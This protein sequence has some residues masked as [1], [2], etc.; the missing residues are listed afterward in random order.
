MCK[1][2]SEPGGP[3]RC[4]G[5]VRAKL[6]ASVA[7]VE[8]LETRHETL[9]RT[10]CELAVVTGAQ[11]HRA[12]SRSRQAAGR[13]DELREEIYEY[14][15]DGAALSEYRTVYRELV[16]ANREANALDAPA[17][18]AL[19]DLDARR[20]HVLSAL[21]HSGLSADEANA[22]LDHIERDTAFAPPF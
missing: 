1:S 15:G 21:Q 20:A 9:F 5:D 17:K 18:A 13:R 3:R 11:R 10:A 14:G 22:Q 16:I 4:A 12:L 6:T 19:A 8:S 7:A 2:A